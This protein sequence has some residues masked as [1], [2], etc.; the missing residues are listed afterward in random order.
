LNGALGSLAC[1]LQVGYSERHGEIIVI[2]PAA[3]LWFEGT[4]KELEEVLKEAE[5]FR[6]TGFARCSFPGSG[7]SFIILD[8]G[9]VREILE[10][11][12]GNHPLPRTLRDLWGKS[13]IKAGI[14]QI[15]EIPPEV[16]FFLSRI[17]DRRPVITDGHGFAELKRTILAQREAGE[18]SLLDV[19][20]PEGKALLFF[21]RGAVTQ[22]YHTENEGFTVSDLD[23]MKRLLA[24]LSR[25]R[26]VFQA[27]ISR[28]GAD[29]SPTTPWIP[30]LLGGAGQ[31]GTG[32]FL[33]NRLADKFGHYYG[34]GTV[35]FHEGDEGNDFYLIG[36]GRVSIF[37]EREG[38]RKILAEL[39]SGEFFGEM[40]IFNQVP[41]AATAETLENSLLIKIGRDELKVLLYN[42][43]EFRINM[44]K[45]LSRRLRDTVD[46]MM[47]LWDD[48]RAVFLERTIFQILNA[49]PKWLEEGI[50]PGL[51][52]QEI[53]ASS[54]MRFS[55][56]DSLF[57]KLLESGKIEF[58]RGKVIMKEP[59][60]IP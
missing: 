6:L 33:R 28:V 46:S 31:N 50:P 38:R 20:S 22:C 53:A 10:I 25:D 36:N 52:M 37:K 44:V 51:L 16:E 35:L 34:P 41:R 57:R 9:A 3:R 48:P 26:A 59:Q 2:I 4:S 30:I 58:I 1:G 49:D 60:T 40:A 8:G 32:V 12:P 17:F 54:G 29:R 11:G 23:A 18:T 43:Y 21:E 15:F 55:E 45:K 42:S 13:K 19:M 27:H 56:I 5:E 7:Q 47:R 24:A 14:L 39:G